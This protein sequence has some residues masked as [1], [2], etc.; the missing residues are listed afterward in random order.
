MYSRKAVT[1]YSLRCLHFFAFVYLSNFCSF[2]ADAYFGYLAVDFYEVRTNI[3][4][5]RIFTV[6]FIHRY[7][8]FINRDAAKC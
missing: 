3:L 8:R 1:T 4:T 6:H 5:Y 2:D 7:N